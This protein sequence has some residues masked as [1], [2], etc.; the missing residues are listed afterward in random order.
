M[1]HRPVVPANISPAPTKAEMPKKPGATK[2]P[3]NTPVSTSAPAVISEEPDILL[4]RVLRHYAQAGPTLI[5][6]EDLRIQNMTRSARG[7]IEAPGR[8]V[9]AK[10]GLNRSINDAGWGVLQNLL[11]YKAEE[12][13]IE[14]VLV[15]PANTSRTCHQCGHVAAANRSAEAFR[16]LVCGHAAQADTNAARNIL[17]LG[18]SLRQAAA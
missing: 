2:R 6:L 10:A 8:N 16:C 5:V 15:N 4:S 17:R 1:P 11:T 9:A 12:A 18:L 7:T 13:G 3:S 14:V